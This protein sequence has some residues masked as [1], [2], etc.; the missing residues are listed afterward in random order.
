MSRFPSSP[1]RAA[2]RPAV[3]VMSHY[4][5]SIR[6]RLILGFLGLMIAGSMLG[7]CAGSPWA[8]LAVTALATL[9]WC[10]FRLLKVLTELTARRRWEPPAGRGAWH[11][12]DRLIWRSQSEMRA[13]KRRLLSMLRTYS[14]AADALPDAVVVV[15]RTHQRVQWF[16]AAASQLLGLMHPRD[17]GVSIVEHLQP[18]PLAHW[19]AGGRN[20]EPM[21]DAP[22]PVQA[23]TRLNLRLIPYSDDYWLLAARDVSK[24]LRLEQMR[25]DFVANVSHELRTPLTVIHGY[26]DV[27]DPKDFLESGPLLIEM[28]QQSQRMAQ[29]V[30][31]LLTLSRLESQEALIEEHV[32]MESML[33]TLRREAEAH[34]QGRHY[35]EVVDQ[36]Q[37]DLRGS[38]KELHSAFSNLVTNAIRYTQAGGS[39]RIELV[40]QDN[41]VRLRVIDTGFG[42]PDSHIPRLT[43]R[44]YRVHSS[45]CRESGGTGLGL[46]IVKHVLNLHQ[47]QLEINSQVGKG[48]TFSCRFG[49]ARLLERD[50]G[51]PQRQAP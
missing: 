26:L 49:C 11:E 29:L 28:R 34:S 25:R 23:D 27:L 35:I 41:T 47:A 30:E 22:S 42:I 14:A 50:G 13:R 7:V 39:I 45:R 33:S 18:L 32:A 19:L 1:P 38:G 8:G 43:E 31:D 2:G 5:R 40:R 46:S 4:I 44:F 21:L 12:L 9:A 20:T 16:N 15:D 48:S 36:A 6:I 37:C 3:S 51:T 24:L 17:L 10:H